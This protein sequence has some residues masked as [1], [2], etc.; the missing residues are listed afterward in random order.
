MGPILEVEVEFNQNFSNSSV[1]FMIDSIYAEDFSSNPLVA[2]A[3]DFGQ[4]SGDMVSLDFDN[5]PPSSFA[6]ILIIQI[7]LIHH[8]N[9]TAYLKML[10]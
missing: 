1:V 9:I 7:H 4:Y 6:C 3:D 5:K 10:M 8:N 2:V